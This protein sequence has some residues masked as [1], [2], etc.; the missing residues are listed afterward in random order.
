[1]FVFA[2]WGVGVLVVDV[3]DLFVGFC[4]ASRNRFGCWFGLVVLVVVC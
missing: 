2:S 1:M 3:V 4:G